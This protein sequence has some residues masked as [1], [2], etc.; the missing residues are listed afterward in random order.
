MVNVNQ[1]M[2]QH[3]VSAQPHHSVDHVRGMMTRNK[4]GAIPVVGPDGQPVGI[5]SATDLIHDHLKG[6]YSRQW[7]DE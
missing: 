7:V 4:C 5:V 2:S 3:V 6:G 1:L